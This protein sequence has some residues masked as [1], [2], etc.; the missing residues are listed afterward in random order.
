MDT[1]WAP[2]VGQACRGCVRLRALD[3]LFFQ[4]CV[5]LAYPDSARS[6]AHAEQSSRARA[7]RSASG[8][9]KKG[10]WNPT[11]R[12]DGR[13]RHYWL[14]YRTGDARHALHSAH[15]SRH[16]VG[17][18]WSW[19]W[20]TVLHEEARP[21]WLDTG[22]V[23]GMEFVRVFPHLRRERQICWRRSGMQEND[24]NILNQRWYAS[25][26]VWLFASCPQAASEKVSLVVFVV[27][28]GPDVSHH[29]AGHRIFSDLVSTS[30]L[31]RM[32][33]P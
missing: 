19:L 1:F 13:P 4:A 21:Q 32:A 7:G 10:A 26:S 23:S 8:D 15:G 14:L 12:E 6:T 33:L 28:E 2:R 20:R 3:R 27:E 18:P 29:E 22:R 11:G 5:R 31:C 30:N 17:R 25:A 24:K 16:P 9:P